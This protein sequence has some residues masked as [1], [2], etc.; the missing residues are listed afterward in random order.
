[1]ISGSDISPAASKAARIN[2]AV[3]APPDLI[4]IN[5]QDVF[6]INSL[7]NKMIICNPP[8]GI[9]LETTTDLSA[10]YRQLGDFLKQ[11]CTGSTAFIYFGERRY[12]KN[13]GLRSTWKKALYN[14]G[15]DG[16]LA[17]FELY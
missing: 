12:L 17:K 13:I 8:Y 14:G 16:R 10:F 15:L 5:H 9:R 1:M 2:S 4:T 6:N 7:K 3:I 11:R